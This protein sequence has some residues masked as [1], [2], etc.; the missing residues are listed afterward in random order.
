VHVGGGY[1]GVLDLGL[2]RF[3]ELAAVVWAKSHERQ[4]SV[5]TA[6]GA[7]IGAHLQAWRQY[8]RMSAR[9][10][11]LDRHDRKAAAP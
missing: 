4:V 1:L 5:E 3:G 8:R 10:A 7:A 2:V 11:E 9:L 6:G